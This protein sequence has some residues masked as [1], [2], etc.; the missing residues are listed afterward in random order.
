MHRTARHDAPVHHGPL[1]PGELA[2]AVVLADVSLALTVVGQ[3]VPLGS[4]LLIAAIVP[5]VVVGARHR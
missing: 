3:V 4:I 5:L 2:E 1:R